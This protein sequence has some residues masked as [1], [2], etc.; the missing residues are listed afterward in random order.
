V[1]PALLGLASR[2]ASRR[3][4]RLPDD[5]FPRLSVVCAAHNEEPVIA[6]KIRNS[7]ALDYPPGLL[8]VVVVSDGSS[9]RTVPEA[10]Q[11]ADPRLRLIVSETQ[12]GKS[13]SL[14][15]AREQTNG[16]IVLFTDANAMLDPGSARMLAARFVPGVGC[17]SG[18]LRYARDGAETSAGGSLY[19]RYDSAIK[20][21][22]SAFGCLIGG[23]GP[24][25]AIR[26]ELW[27]DLAPAEVPDLALGMTALEA[28]QKAVYVPDAFCV[29]RVAESVGH[30]QRRY[31]RIIGRSISTA[32]RCALRLLAK[33]RLTAL[34][35]LFWH[36]L[37][38][39]FTAPLLIAAVALAAL[40][41]RE[42][43]GALI[44]SASALAVLLALLG[45]FL[46]LRPLRLAYYAASV[47]GAGGL[48]V[49]DWVLGRTS[50]TW[51]VPVRSPDDPAAVQA[52]SVED[53]AR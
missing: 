13:A 10:R 47:L 50:P 49:L 9:D 17:V 14:N 31:R 39:Y 30:E 12:N 4:D 37:A 5:Q 32:G 48:G 20:R 28:G 38:R 7:L 6:G 23:V 35:F 29:E 33:G 25:F 2:L 15:L 19:W 1:W 11:I 26:R 27:R 24:I 44:L 52:A 8:E 18:E 45:R 21:A 16:D 40:S 22:E 42:T 3:A 34:W 43:G 51:S 36:K 53:H 46:P 41:A